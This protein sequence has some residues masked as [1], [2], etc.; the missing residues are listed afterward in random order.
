MVFNVLSIVFT[1]ISKKIAHN[2]PA[3]YDVGAGTKGLA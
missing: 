1:K 2:V 3:V